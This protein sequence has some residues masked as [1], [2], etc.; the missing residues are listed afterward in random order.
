MKILCRAAL[1]I[2]CFLLPL[3]FAN[4]LVADDDVIALKDR[5]ELFVD[6]FL[7]DFIRGARLEM[8]APVAREKVLTVDQ[9]WEGVYS[10]Y[11]TVIDDRGL[12][13][14]YYR[15]LPV[16]KHNLD[17]EVTCYAES[18]DGIH[19][20]KPNLGLYEVQGTKE[21]NVVLA[22]HRACHNFA[23][24]LDSNPK[25]AVDQKYKAL[26]GTGKPGLIALASP[27]GI[28]WKELKKEPVLTEGAFDSQNVS[29]WS[30]SENCYVC[31]FRVF[32][33]GKRWIARATSQDFLNWSEP[34]DMA[35]PGDRT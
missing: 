27:D 1:A 8:H 32:R 10:G 5:R 14:M 15:G 20:T 7:I 3:V 29:F 2:G 16:A 17:S 28:H 23:P 25:A 22:R 35:L 18:K 12:F 9:P 26:G 11:F 4:S 31:Y 34:V 21:N 19:W 30:E 24:F 13:R 33:E 6:P